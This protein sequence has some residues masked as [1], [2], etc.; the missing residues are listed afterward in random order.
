MTRKEKL[1]FK[2]N[3]V[4]TEAKVIL[5]KTMYDFKSKEE[6]DI[7]LEVNDWVN[8]LSSIIERKTQ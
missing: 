1:E 7:R 8:V 5:L 2:K 6:P 3:R 4:K